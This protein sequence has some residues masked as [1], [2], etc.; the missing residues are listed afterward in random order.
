MRAQGYVHYLRYSHLSPDRKSRAVEVWGNKI[1]TVLAPE[2]DLA[3]DDNLDKILTRLL[4][5]G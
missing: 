1:G 4:S 3:E 5:V 2:A